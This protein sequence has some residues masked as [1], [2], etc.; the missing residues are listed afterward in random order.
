[1]DPL[2]FFFYSR[3]VV[4][5]NF[6]SFVPGIFPTAFGRHAAE[7]NDVPFSLLLD[8]PTLA[9]GLLLCVT[10]ILCFSLPTVAPKTQRRRRKKG[11]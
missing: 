10:Y 11:Q 6:T 1:M 7:K 5:R 9:A 4:A 2:F 3:I 8:A